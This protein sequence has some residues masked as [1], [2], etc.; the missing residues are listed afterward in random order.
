MTADYVLRIACPADRM[1]TLS[2]IVGAEPTRSS[3][4]YWSFEVSER[5][6]EGPVPF[7]DIFLGLLKGKY[8]LLAEV[9]I[10]RRHVSV[11]IYC[12]YSDQCN[13]QLLAKD[14]RR[15]GEEQIDLC[16]SC[17][18]TEDPQEA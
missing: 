18:Q 4:G 14:L 5:A 11:W 15:L 13:L 12:E 3:H 8:D 7:V 1:A 10:A 2:R 17:W 6:T 16:I 9:G